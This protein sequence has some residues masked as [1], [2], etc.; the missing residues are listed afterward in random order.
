MAKS[1]GIL[2]FILLSAFISTASADC[3]Y[4]NGTDRNEGT[5]V[6]PGTEAYV[7]CNQVNPFSMCC[8]YGGDDCLPNGLCQGYASD[9]SKPVWRESC[10]DPTWTSPY[11]LRLCVTGEDAKG[12][13]R[14]S[15]DET[16]HQCPDGSY[17]CGQYNTTCCDAGDGQ[18]IVNGQATRINPNAT[19]TSSSSASTTSS[20]TS[21]TSTTTITAAAGQGNLSASSNSGSGTPTGAIAGGV[22]GGIAVIAIGIGAIWYLRR[23]SKKSNQSSGPEQYSSPGAPPNP[24]YQEAF[25]PIQ[26]PGL[27]EADGGLDRKSATEVDSQA[28]YEIGYEQKE[29]MGRQELAG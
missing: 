4:P 20:S 24:P 27:H 11:C 13:D 19:T 18:W 17:C 26:H 28:R 6:T 7:P 1:R 8:R 21:S 3:F 9:G 14:N 25:K 16:V 2:P 22:V 23:R 12:L 29:K 10:T 15:N 5:D